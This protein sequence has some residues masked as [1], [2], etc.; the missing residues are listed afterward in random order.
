M[1]PTFW[2]RFW[3]MSVALAFL[4]IWVG[5]TIWHWWMIFF[6]LVVSFIG[7]LIQ[8]IKEKK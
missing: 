8:I 7:G 1:I 3:H 2:D 5:G 6:P 4:G